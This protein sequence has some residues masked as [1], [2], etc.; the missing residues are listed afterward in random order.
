MKGMKIKEVQS[1]AQLGKAIGKGKAVA[2]FHAS[3]C[4]FCRAFRPE[5]AKLAGGQKN[6]APLEVLMDDEESPLWEKHEI[7]AVPTILFFDQGKV[8]KR[9]DAKPGVG[10]SAKE[11]AAVLKKK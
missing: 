10:L 2:L 11:L 8:K 7:S 9:L 6:W 5:F 4:P 1:E 3:W